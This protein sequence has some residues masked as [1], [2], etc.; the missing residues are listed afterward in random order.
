MKKNFL[1][2]FFIFYFL[3]L[4][5]V[6]SAVVEC[7][8]TPCSWEDF[9]SSILNLIKTI[10]WFSFWIAVLLCTI[11]AFL[12]MFHGPK[13]DF[14]QKGKNLIITALIGYIL[15]LAS[16]IIFDLILEFFA[17]TFSFL[18]PSVILAAS[19]SLTP[20]TYL[21][22]LKNAITEG[23]K[24]GI[25]AQTI[26]ERLFSCI[27]EAIDV[28]KNLALI[29]LT[30]AI[31]GS[32]AYLITTPLFGLKNINRAYQILIWSI[33]GLVI[34]LLADVIRVQIEQLVQ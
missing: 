23:L 32:G 19:D 26:L 12:M 30:L 8:Q 14:Y 25:N 17:P 16:G 15:I 21:D 20:T 4:N 9:F 28:L 1:I 6:F 34:I 3:F 10:V 22:P 33:I 24:C 31:I 2:L 27:F 13:P 7:Q 29:L 11:G 5:F 18:I